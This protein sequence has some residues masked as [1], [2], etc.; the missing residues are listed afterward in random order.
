MKVLIAGAN[1]YVGQHVKEH[2]TSQGLEVYTYV[3]AAMA[4]VSGS[5]VVSRDSTD[6]Y[7]SFDVVINCARPHWSAHSPEEI[8]A[9]EQALLKTLTQFAKPQAQKIHTSGVWLFGHS[10]RS[11]LEAFQLKPFPCV[12]Q[13]VATIEGALAGG[14]QIVYLPSL[15]YGSRDCQLVRNAEALSEKIRDVA[16]PSVGYNQYIHVEDAARFYHQMIAQSLNEPQYF[17]AEEQGYS[18][19]EFARLLLACGLIEKMNPISWEVFE[20]KGEM[21]ADIQRLNLDLPITPDFQP[22]S[23]LQTYLSAMSTQLTDMG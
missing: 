7:G 1:G 11:D 10:T 23:D 9:I 8:V 20:E 5:Q 19:L 6:A 13:D 14:W 21:A 12:S 18:P 4:Q 16:I 17:I 15:V 2:L 3:R 22:T